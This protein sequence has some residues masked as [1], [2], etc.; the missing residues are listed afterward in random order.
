MLVNADEA[1]VSVARATLDGLLERRPEWATQAG[2]HR[3]DHRLTAGTPAHYAEVSRWAADRLR[4]LDDLAPPQVPSPQGPSPH[5]LSAQNWVDARILRTHLELL[6]FELDE[7]REHE[8]N[9]MLANPGRAIYLLLAR[10]FAPLPQRLQSVAAR[11]AAIPESLAASR[12]VLGPM[13]RI[14]IE[15]A[16]GQFAGTARLIGA[17]LDRALESVADDGQP[18]GGRARDEVNG[19][20]AAAVRA[21][22]EHR[23]WLRQRLTDGD[24]P[25]QPGDHAG[26]G[27][28]VG[29]DAGRGGQAG[30]DA[31]RGGR[32]AF[33]DPRIGPE[34]FTAKLRLTLDAES[35]A[36]DILSRA[37]ADLERVTEQIAEAAAELAAAKPGSA[38]SGAPAGIVRDVLDRLAADAPDDATILDLVRRVLAAETG[39]VREHR[40]VSV[41]DDPV[42]VIEMP[43]IDRGVAVAYCDPPGPLETAPL[44]TFVA[45]APTPEDW[46]PERVAS[47]YREYNRHNLHNLIAHEAVPGHALQLQHSG[48]FTAGTQVRAALWSGSF[49]EGWAVYAERLMA[50]HRYPAEGGHAA[51][52]MQR[53]KMQLRMILNAILDAR[54]HCEGMPEADAMALM[55]GRAYQEEAEASGKWRRALLTSAQLST[56]YVGYTEVSDLAADLRAANP[57]WPQQRLHDTLL[58]HGS[59]PARHLRTLLAGD[60]TT[61]RAG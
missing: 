1:F 22:E 41:Y 8:W 34:L 61:T 57:G 51:F 12:S 58:A 28:Q 43:E 35:D 29:A 3:H 33:R 53:L 2:D 44:P 10:D 40:I 50:E 39:F 13:P 15:T 23:R 11:L 5:G 47:F 36:G 54:V 37:E 26:R 27:Q 48:R 60:L 52:Q 25:G 55:T 45:V 21:I 49:A 19:V 32:E 31:G 16:L 30:A 7:I 6:R 17:E 18:G 14:H 24:R 4:D 20:R 59:P 9:P 56:Y 46:T 42:D 38:R